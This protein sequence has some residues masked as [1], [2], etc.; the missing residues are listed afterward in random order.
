MN[1]KINYDKLQNALEFAKLTTPE[2][3]DEYREQLKSKGMVCITETRKTKFFTFPKILKS[4][5]NP[6]GFQR[7]GIVPGSQEMKTSFLHIRPE[8][9]TEGPDGRP[10]IDRCKCY[11]NGEKPAL[12]TDWRKTNICQSCLKQ[13]RFF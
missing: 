1:D 12:L 8:P 5:I 10:E 6:C 9:A 4:I 13:K 2:M 3:D 11:D 7:G